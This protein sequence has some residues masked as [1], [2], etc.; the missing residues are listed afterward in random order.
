MS[1]LRLVVPRL[2][3]KPEPALVQYEHLWGKRQNA[4]LPQKTTRKIGTFNY[5]ADL[6]GLREK[7][8]E[9]RLCPRTRRSK[10]QCG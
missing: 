6:T 2:L 7:L 3:E 9:S 4:P 5:F 1:R 8:V 10:Q